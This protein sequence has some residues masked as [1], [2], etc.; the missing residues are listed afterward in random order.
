[1]ISTLQ[2]VRNLNSCAAKSISFN[3]VR[4]QSSAAN[5]LVL[6]DVD[7]STGVSTLTM[8]RAPVNS[9]SLELLSA[10]S[11]TLDDL[12]SDKS[13]GMILTSVR[14]NIFQLKLLANIF[15]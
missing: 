1:M 6:V 2:F 8:N 15:I 11:K 10:I 4:R 5:D 3:L 7:P 12:K 14:K 13:R 9:L